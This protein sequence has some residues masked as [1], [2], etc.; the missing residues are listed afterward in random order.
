MKSEKLHQDRYKFVEKY[1]IVMEK[2]KLS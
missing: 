2:Y 1:D